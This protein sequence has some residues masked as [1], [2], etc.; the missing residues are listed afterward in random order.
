MEIC[1][2]NESCFYYQK[3]ICVF[4]GQDEY[5]QTIDINK[6]NRLIFYQTSKKKQCNYNST[7]I[8]EEKKLEKQ[9]EVEKKL[10]P[11]E[12]VKPVIVITYGDIR[13]FINNLL[14]RYDVDCKNYF[15]KLNHYMRILG[16]SVH[17][18]TIET[19]SDL[20][21]R[22]SKKPKHCKK[23]IYINKSSY[24]SQ[25]MGEYH[26]DSEKNLEYYDGIY[27]NNDISLNWKTEK[28]IENILNMNITTKKQKVDISQDKIKIDNNIKN[29][30]EYLSVLEEIEI[31]EEDKDKEDKED[32]EDKDKEDKEDTDNEED[33]EKEE[34]GNFD[35]ENCSDD[36][37]ENGDNYEDFSD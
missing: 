33:K 5:I 36:D 6:C 12:V 16:Y 26:Y 31:N 19:F 2:C 18:P 28:I 22:L 25:A 11:I 27:N 34:D 14:K 8:I 32:K 3:K 17:D 10:E 37:Y 24:T 35:V 20:K 23:R 7:K 29:K 4:K 9:M 1:D 21:Y 30:I 13:T 15:G